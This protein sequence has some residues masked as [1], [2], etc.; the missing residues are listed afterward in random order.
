MVILGINEGIDASVVLCWNGMIIFAVQEERLNR[1]KGYIGFPTQAIAYCLK[2]FSLHAG[3]LSH[4][5][6]S[7]LHSP[8]EETRADLLG[9][10]ASSLRPWYE[11]L[12]AGDMGGLGGWIAS[13]LPASAEV[14]L[15]QWRLTRRSIDQNMTVEQKLASL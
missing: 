1:H 5:C 14:A 4:V 9:Y 12:V 3:N 15:T 2:A 10:Y 13:R 7:N 11:G 6:F 8:L